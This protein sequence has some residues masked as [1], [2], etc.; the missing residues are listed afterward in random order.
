M[1]RTKIL[2]ITLL[3][4]LSVLAILCC[5]GSL[6]AFGRTRGSPQALTFL[7]PEGVA[8]IEVKGVVTTDS[9][10]SPFVIASRT[11]VETL[12][13]A[14]ENPRVAAI[15]LYVNSPGGDAVASDEVYRALKALKKPTVAYLGD[16]AASGAYYIACGADKIVAHPATLT[17]SIG[18]IVEMPNAQ[19]F[20]ERLGLEVVV[21]KSGPHKDVGNF[22]RSL[23][24][25]EKAYWQ[26][27]V[28]RVHEMFLEVIVRER[29]LPEE[30]LKPIA[31]GRLILGED[32]LKFGLVDKLGSFDDALR[33]AGELGGIEGEPRI[34]RYRIAPS[35]IESLLYEIRNLLPVTPFP[36]LMFVYK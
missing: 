15:L 7:G 16:I 32:A 33:L 25:E 31:D 24:E 2:W 23:T 20:M 17:G 36:R 26:E 19:K 8:L 10:S 21:I 35:F 18:V 22:Y 9:Y 34:I 4:G 3:L 12:R 11:L 5:G 6:L 1:K 28:N 29:G 30:K 14:D 27:L 13:S